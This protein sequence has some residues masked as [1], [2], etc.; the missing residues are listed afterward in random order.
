[1]LFKARVYE[2]VGDSFVLKAA[3]CDLHWKKFS[4]RRNKSEAIENSR[5]KGGNSISR[6][7]N[8]KSNREI[9]MFTKI[10][11]KLT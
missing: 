10:L 3:K 1:M 6:A 11:L 2:S 7:V 8:S 4:M 9:S 5:W